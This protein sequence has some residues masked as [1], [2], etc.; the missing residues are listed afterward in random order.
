MEATA[1]IALVALAFTGTQAW[2]ARRKLQFDLFT[3]RYE[4]WQAFND[5]VEARRAENAALQPENMVVLNVGEALHQFFRLRR[6]M[7]LLFPPEVE[8]G[9]NAIDT[10]LQVLA[11]AA[12]ARQRLAVS[13][14]EA[15]ELA[16]AQML[17]FTNANTEILHLQESLM[18]LVQPYLR[19]YGL[20]EIYG[21][22]AIRQL[23][24]GLRRIPRLQRRG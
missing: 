9:I 21:V 13:S 14:P 3:K 10:A 22:P 19:Q 20:W 7:V 12:V 1:W 24:A 16:I 11:L 17:A 15:G 4:V 23:Q 5:A 8:E 6:Q 2:I 18:R